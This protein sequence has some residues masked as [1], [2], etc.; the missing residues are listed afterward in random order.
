MLQHKELIA[1]YVITVHY[2][3]VIVVNRNVVHIPNL[4]LHWLKRG[5][6]GVGRSSAAGVGVWAALILKIRV[7]LA[8]LENV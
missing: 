4:F 3:E 8:E 5:A 2:K 6:A 1:S 7:L